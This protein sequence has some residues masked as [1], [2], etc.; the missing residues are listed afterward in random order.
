MCKF[1]IFSYHIVYLLFL[2]GCIILPTSCLQE[3][4]EELLV[5][6]EGRR[7]TG[8]NNSMRLNETLLKTLQTPQAVSS[9]HAQQVSIRGVPRR[10][11]NTGAFTHLKKTMD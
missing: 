3:I 1:E 10:A 6:R 5:T 2:F 9:Q 7:R 8:A 11:V 4:P